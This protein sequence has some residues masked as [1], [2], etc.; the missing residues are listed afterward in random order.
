MHT[1]YAR[2]NADVMVQPAFPIR[3]L[4]VD[5]NASFLAAARHVL[6]SEEVTVVAVASTSVDALRVF[7]AL[8]P[9]VTLVDIDLGRENGFDLAEELHQAGLPTPSPV[10][11]IS[12]HDQEDFAD[13]I[14]AYPAAGFL[15][16]SALSPAAIRELLRGSTSFQEGDTANQR[17][18]VLCVAGRIRPQ[19]TKP[20][21]ST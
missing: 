8:R 14:A 11:L 9:D 18:N 12:N 4:I 21:L 2:W 16:K 19:R 5:D 1:I 15:A 7:H 20:S 10:I 17:R 13:M 3:C 6:E